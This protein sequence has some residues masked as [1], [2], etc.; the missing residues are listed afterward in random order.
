MFSQ[1][2]YQLTDTWKT[3]VGVRYTEDEKVADEYRTRVVFLGNP[4]LPFSFYSKRRRAHLEGKWSAATGTAG[5]EWS[6]SEDLLAYG[7]YTR[8]YKSGGFN[9]GAMAPGRTGY[10]EPEFINAFELGLKQTFG[11]A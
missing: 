11:S 5:L 7:K 1:V 6:P 4:A 2:D 10:T 3:T 8:G 9:A